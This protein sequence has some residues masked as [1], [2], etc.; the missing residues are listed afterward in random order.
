[1]AS[2]IGRLSAY[3]SPIFRKF[4]V[5]AERYVVGALQ[6]LALSWLWARFDAVNHVFN[7]RPIKNELPTAE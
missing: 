3:L 4:R 1:M 5:V 7:V 2:F 6:P